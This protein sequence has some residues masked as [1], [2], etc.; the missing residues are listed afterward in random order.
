MLGILFFVVA[1]LYA[2]VGFG[3]GSSYLALLVLWE[4]PY[5]II[6]ILALLCNIVVVSGNSFNYIRKGLLKRSIIWPLVLTS[7]PL[8]FIGGRI[9]IEKELFV[10]ILFFTLLIAGLRLLITHKKYDDKPDSYK[11]LPLPASLTIGSILAVFGWN[12][13][14]RR[15][16]IPCAYLILFQGWCAKADSGGFFN[17]YIS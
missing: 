11:S 5:N 1:L 7:V 14:H 6:P 9:P 12:Y 2:A 15:W 16:D 17:V 10:I 4:M 13:R 8:S 3:G